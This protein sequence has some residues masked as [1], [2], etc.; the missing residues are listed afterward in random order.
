[1]VKDVICSLRDV[2][3]KTRYAL[4][5]CSEFQP[6]VVNPLIAFVRSR[7]VNF[8]HIVSWGDDPRKMST[9]PECG[10]ACPFGV[11]VKHCAVP[12]RLG[13]LVLVHQQRTPAVPK[14]RG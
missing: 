12:I 6:C 14:L 5:A 9:E 1:M 3:D 11:P 7:A 13:K 8:F 10:E 4:R 2:P